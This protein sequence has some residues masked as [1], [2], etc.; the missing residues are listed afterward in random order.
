MVIGSLDGSLGQAARLMLSRGAQIEHAST[1]EQGLAVL[2]RVGSIDAV[3]CDIV[4]PIDALVQS[5]VAARIC[6]PVIACGVD[7]E[8][9]D[10]AGAIRAGAREFL[11]L[12]PD[13]TLIAAILESLSGDRTTVVARDPA[14]LTLLRRAEMVATAEASILLTGASGTGKEVLARFIHRKSRRRDKPFVAV[15][16][17]A[18]P[19]TLLESELFGYEK[20][21]FT[22]A[23]SRR[24]GKFEAAE[25]GTLLLDEIS[26]MDVQLQAKLLRVLQEREL[27]RLGGSRPV[28]I[29]VRIVATSNRDILT[30]IRR[31]AFREDLYFRLNVVNLRIPDLAERPR[32]IPPLA[33]HFAT[34]FAS[35]NGLPPRPLTPAYHR[36]LLSHSWPGNVRELENAVH[37]SVLL[38]TGDEIDEDSLEFPSQPVVARQTDFTQASVTSMGSLVGRKIEDVERELILNTLVSTSG[39]RTHA[40]MV[41]GISIR[42]LRNKLKDYAASGATVPPPALGVVA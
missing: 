23:S 17:A 5:V 1:V 41:L 25:G 35:L 30:E 20:G 32:D 14:T 16:C 21:A 15:N 31:G 2:R 28:P 3:F 7:T 19:G 33:D 26:E 4:L 6:V 13:A 27:D 38:A 42:A 29:N 36:R 11:P 40:A 9:D 8:G 39:N 34:Y 24:I 10:A 18:I 12:P 22:G 37:R